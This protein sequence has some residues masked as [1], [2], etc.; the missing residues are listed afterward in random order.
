MNFRLTRLEATALGQCTGVVETR[1]GRTIQV[2]FEVRV[3]RGVSYVRVEPPT[4]DRGIDGD[5]SDFH[6]LFAAAIAFCS[7][8]SFDSGDTPSLGIE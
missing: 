8:S 7:V 3:D 4:F 5:A 2:N 1:D 6:R